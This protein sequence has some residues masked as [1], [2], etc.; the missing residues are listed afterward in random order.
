[1]PKITLSLFIAMIFAL[2]GC[3]DN[4][5]NKDV[6][7]TQSNISKEELHKAQNLDKTSYSGLEHVFLDTSKI[8]SNNKYVMLIFGKNNCQWCDRLKDDI[9]EDKKTQDI[10]LKSFNSYY[11]NLSYSKQHL[12]DFDGK[13]NTIDT[14]TL[15]MQ[16]NIRPTPTIVFLDK[17]GSPI[18]IY[19]G[20]LPQEQFRVFLNFISS[21][22][23]LN[24]K[25][26]KQMQE[27]L[28]EKL[29]GE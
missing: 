8:Y 5:I 26:Q 18:I 17:K 28:R 3:K 6:F 12:I 27:M 1:M 13:T 21:G 16:Y 11:I 23:Y 9:K 7:S 10:M 14:P 29:Q 20:Y 24:A 4:T 19:P 22:E 15:A 25:N 2:A